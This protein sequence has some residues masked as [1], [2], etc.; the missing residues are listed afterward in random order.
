MDAEKLVEA[1]ARTIYEEDD[2]WHKAW[3]WPD[4][5]SDQAGVDQY[6]RI[7][8]AALTV[9]LPMLRDDLLPESAPSDEAI[10]HALKAV[11]YKYFGDYE[12]SED[13]WDAVWT[14][15]NA[16]GRVMAIRARF[17]EIAKEVQGNE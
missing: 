6:R 8:R 3:P 11:D 14:M 17:D 7:A 2:P 10:K 9:A 13:Q 12:L 15:H 4:L 16:A 5:Q 1:V